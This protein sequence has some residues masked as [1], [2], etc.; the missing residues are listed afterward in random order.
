MREIDRIGEQLRRAAEGG[1]WHGPSLME[2]LQGITAETAAA[3]PYP[4]NTVWEILN[5]LTAWNRAVARRLGGETLELQGDA[6]FPPARENSEAAWQAAVED[7]RASLAEL[8][9]KMKSMGNEELGM[10]VPGCEYNNW[11]MLNGVVQHYAY[12][13]GQIALLRKAARAAAGA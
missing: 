9:S 7:F 8:R 12:H 4:G 11:L 1:A 6:D 3:R 13:S 5:H 10:P 2:N